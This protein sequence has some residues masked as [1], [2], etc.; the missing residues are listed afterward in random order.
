MRAY[1][2]HRASRGSGFTLVEIMI[3]VAIVGLLA[4][5]AIP[6]FVRSRQVSR[7]TVC[8]NDL[9]I[10]QDALDLYMFAHNVFPTDLNELVT[11]RYLG[12]LIECPVGGSYEWSVKNGN[13]QYHLRCRGQHSSSIGH[14]CIH[15]N[16]PPEAK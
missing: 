4:A 8:L 14:V 10:C 13:T 16:Q 7:L 2:Q 1:A 9:R 6:S 12:K 3:V 15:E 11:E 5:L